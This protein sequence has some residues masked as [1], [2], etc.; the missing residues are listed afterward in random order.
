MNSFFLYTRSHMVIAV[1][2][3]IVCV[4]CLSVI[5]VI[6]RIVSTVKR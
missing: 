2:A 6:T 1:L 3:H 5:L 4:V